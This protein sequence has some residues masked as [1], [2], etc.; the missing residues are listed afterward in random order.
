M[1]FH[2]QATELVHGLIK[3]ITEQ[4]CDWTV[5][6]GA[7]RHS[8]SAIKITILPCS[9]HILDDVRVSRDGV[10]VWLPLSQRLK[11][12][13]AMRQEMIKRAKSIFPEKQQLI[14]R[15]LHKEKSC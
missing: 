11:L 5:E 7:M 1:T 12:R 8:K 4:P 10:D 9:L 13:R 15:S 6:Y 14:C 3:N 2:K